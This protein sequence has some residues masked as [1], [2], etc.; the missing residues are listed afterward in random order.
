MTFLCSV[1]AERRDWFDHHAAVQWSNLVTRK[2]GSFD[3]AAYI[4]L[5]GLTQCFGLLRVAECAFNEVK[6]KW[7]SLVTALSTTD[8]SGDLLADHV[9]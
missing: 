6:T 2:T 9:T 1:V 3:L 5:I 7:S 4:H 8:Q